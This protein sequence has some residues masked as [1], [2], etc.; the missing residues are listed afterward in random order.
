M[1]KETEKNGQR[2]YFGLKL[3]LVL[4]GNVKAD[5]Q[6]NKRTNDRA[7]DVQTDG[8]R[9]NYFWC[10]KSSVGHCKVPTDRKTD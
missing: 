5:R 1:K 3:S 6:M 4:N 8:I 9:I 10:Q 2:F 7:L